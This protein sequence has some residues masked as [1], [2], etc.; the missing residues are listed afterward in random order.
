MKVALICPSNI[1]YMPYVGNYEM[2][3]KE[4]NI[5]YDIINWDRFHIEN[6]DNNLKYRD[7]KIGHQR[8]F[9]DYYKYKKFIINCLNMVHYDKVIVFGIQLTFFLK[10]ILQKKFKYKYII[11]IR[12]YNKIIN[13]FNIKKVIDNSYFTV[14]SSPGYKEWLPNSGKYIINHNTQI[15]SINTLKEV[16]QFKKKDKINIAYIGAIRDL[17]ININLI[18]SLKNSDRINIY[19]HG[20]GKINNDIIKYINAN[21]IKN[22]YLTG[23]Y[24][25][26]EE[27]NLYRK[28]DLINVLRYFNGIN[29]KTALPNRLYNSVIYGKF[30][31]AFEGTYLS[32]LIK[33]Y[34]LGIVI[35]SFDNLEGKVINFLYNINIEDYN[36]GRIA[37]VEKV[38]KENREFEVKVKKFVNSN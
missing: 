4:N 24:K 36:N 34:N 14:I 26:E 29:N 27:E 2:I 23:R 9:F 33:R 11:D 19:F 20:E 16:K 7:F 21:N 12:D 8:N 18:N 10:N 3:L 1:L 5:N 22:V 15:S 35:D 17:Q 13:F 32:E 37:F 30:M 31:L 28:S 25:K 38:L 6:I